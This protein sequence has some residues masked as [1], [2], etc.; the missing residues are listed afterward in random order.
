MMK[1]LLLAVAMV[2]A[3]NAFAGE[4]PAE[5]EKA[6]EAKPAAKKAKKGKKT[7]KKEK[8]APKKA[9]PADEGGGDEM[10]ADAEATP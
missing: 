4:P 5:G 7:A 8:K 2:F 9:E 1:K 3:F 6:A 10:P